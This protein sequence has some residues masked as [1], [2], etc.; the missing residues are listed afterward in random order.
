M[1]F[2]RQTKKRQSIEREELLNVRPSPEQAHAGRMRLVTIGLS[3]AFL[4]A[5][6]WFV[7]WK[8]GS[9][10]LNHCVYNSPAF[11]IRQIDVQTDGV[12]SA[13]SIRNWAAVRSGEN[14]LVL[15]LM[16]L[17]RDL[18]SQPWIKTVA[19]ERLLPHTLKLRVSEREAVAQTMVMQPHFIGDFEKTI[20]LLDEDGFT[21]KPL[22][23]KYQAS[24][25]GMSIDHLP[26][27]LGVQVNEMQAGRQVESPQIR[28]ALDLL[29]E[30]ERSPMYGLVE[31]QRIN[32]SSPEILQVTTSQG[33]EITFSLNN[34]DLQFR[35]WR[36][37]YE[38]YEKSGRAVASL[39]LSIAN[40]LPVRWVAA[41]TLQP[42]APKVVRPLR[43]RK[44]HV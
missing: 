29:I 1:L 35:R 5:L 23:P 10:T 38:M 37:I 21:M 39:D 40:N 12:L 8:G 34:F 15:D 22:D 18:E 32:V 28:A 27:L 43:L 7:C 26:M 4:V 33:A 44:K 3:V 11:S 9:Y 6:V 19:I 41:N 2:R 42:I 17:K 13:E 14:L 25:T 16:R 20:F 30:Y 24:Q 31:L 36:A